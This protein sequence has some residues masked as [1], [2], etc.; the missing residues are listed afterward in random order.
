M[1]KI[2]YLI[3]AL[4]TVGLVQG[5]DEVDLPNFTPPSPE[6]SEFT[7]YGDVEVNESLGMVNTSIP[8]YTYQAGH[9]QLPISLQY[10][11]SGVKVNQSSTWTGINWTLQ[12]GGVISRTV[13]DEPDEVESNRGGIDYVNNRIAE[14]DVINC[15][16]EDL[17]EANYLLF[18]LNGLEQVDRQPDLFTFSFMGYSGSFYLNENFE[19]VFSK[20]DK[21]LKIEIIG[22]QT[23]LKDRLYHNNTFCITTP[24]GVKYYFGGAEA[25]ESSYTTQISNHQWTYSNTICPTAY[26][27]YEIVHPVNG[28]INFEYNESTQER[29][30]SIDDYQQLTVETHEDEVPDDF[31]CDPSAST[32]LNLIQTPTPTRIKSRVLDSKSLSRIY[33][34]TDP[35]EQVLFES[36]N[37]SSESYLRVL[38][39]IRVVRDSVNFKTVDLEYIYGG[40]SVTASQRFFLSKV[41][42]D[43]EINQANFLHEV[44]NDVFEMKYD[45]ALS[46]PD[47][48][49]YSQDMLGYYNGKTFNS[50]L[51]PENDSFY[52]QN[53]GLADRKPYFDFAKRGSLKKIIYPTGGYTEFEYEARKAKDYQNIIHNLSIWRNS[54]TLTPSTQS[55]DSYGNTIDLYGNPEELIPPFD[56]DYELYLELYP[57]GNIGHTDKIKIQ[58]HDLTT[59][60]TET[61][62]YQFDYPTLESFYAVN[63]TFSVE[64]GHNYLLELD[65]TDPTNSVPVRVDAVLRTKEIVII[66][67]FGIRVKTVKDFTDSNTLATT[68]RYYYHSKEEHYI[69]E[70]SRLEFFRVPFNSYDDM[71]VR[72]CRWA[73]NGVAQ[74]L[75]RK[76]YQFGKTTSVSI[77]KIPKWEKPYEYVMVSYGGGN[78]EKGGVEKRFTVNEEYTDLVLL[79][80]DTPLP[81]AQL[82]N[83]NGN[84]TSTKTGL[85][86]KETT[87]LNKNFSLYKVKEKT[88]TYDFTYF[89]DDTMTGFMGGT[90]DIVCPAFCAYDIIRTLYIKGYYFHSIRVDLINTNIKEYIDP[91]PVSAVPVDETGYNKIVQNIDYTYGDLPGLP[92][93]INTTSSDGQVNTNKKYYVNDIS[94]LT[95][96]SADNLNAYNYLND[97]NQVEKPI[98]VETYK[99]GNLTSQIRTLYKSWSVEEPSHVFPESILST[100][101]DLSLRKRVV[102]HEYDFRGNPTIVSLSGGIKT[103]Y[104]YNFRNQ[105]MSKIVNYDVLT[106]PPTDTE[107]E[108]VFNGLPSGNCTI[109]NNFPNSEVTLFDYDNFNK[110]IKYLIDNNCQKQIYEYDVFNRLKTIKVQYDNGTIDVLKE[111]DYNYKN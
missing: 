22:N 86:L 11:G 110:K 45:N 80:Q 8:V 105:V 87:L 52:F 1:N 78:F 100:K 69:D 66:D 27:L 83:Y 73:P 42:F 62:Y 97:I 109:Q 102:F 49:A 93:E 71:A 76:F 95:G 35:Q 94:T 4:F 65:F 33:S 10:S 25:T 29:L 59:S 36:Q 85:L 104:S 5:Q 84:V 43:K 48:F 68:K 99:S 40:A 77:L 32:N 24:D 64:E 30:L 23:N 39:K 15:E 54:N 34:L 81:K 21:A 50:T 38:N 37:S 14:I 18:L 106:T 82:A 63:Y 96:L 60:T 67:D 70:F 17:Y 108:N 26:Y 91:V 79:E 89:V 41:I 107:I 55:H 31:I 103:R 2:K 6:V 56:Q 101:G 75:P 46:L 47:R 7:K 3:I 61:V 28:R 111:F 44:Q 19:P 74:G 13:Y 20:I 51:I 57:E 92:T 72:C 58:L 16:T 98:Q 12:A 88:N 90:K 9:L 53:M